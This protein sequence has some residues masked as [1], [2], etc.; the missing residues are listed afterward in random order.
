MKQESK[1]VTPGSELGTEVIGPP[2]FK[3]TYE[4]FLEAFSDYF[5]RLDMNEEK[6][7]RMI[8]RRD[9][10]LGRSIGL[11]EGR[12][13]VGFVL[14]GLREKD[15]SLIG[16]DAGTALRPQYRGKGLARRLLEDNLELL[17][18]QGVE[19][20]VL[21][22]I[23]ENDPAIGLYESFGFA[24]VRRLRCLKLEDPAR[25]DAEKPVDMVRLRECALSSAPWPIL[26]PQR[27]F[28]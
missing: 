14:N 11:F 1:G 2:R 19:E 21:E 10:D 16:Y 7:L 26:R 24:T 5:V 28:I 27:F 4:T 23:T 13:M 15:R 8:R 18:A 9:V 6:L 17:R 20:Y 25:I 3:E 12:R 22:V